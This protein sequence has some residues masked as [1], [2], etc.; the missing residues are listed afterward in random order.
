MTG[1]AIVVGAGIGGLAAAIGLRRIGWDVTVLE[2]SIEVGEIGAG[3]SQAPNALRALDAL[4]VG[5]QA[6]AAGTPFFATTNLRAPSGRYLM[7]APSGAPHSLLGFHRADLHGVLRDAVPTASIQTGAKVTGFDHTAEHARVHIGDETL[8]ADLVAAADGIHSTAR[9]LL[10]PGTPEPAF[11]NYTVWR[12][13]A[14]LDLAAHEGCMTMGTDRYFLTMPL[15]RG[16]VYWAL[17][18]RAEAPG[19]RYADERE[20]VRERVAGWHVLIQNL[21]DATAADRVLHHD[22]T[23]L[24]HAP[25]PSLVNGRIALLG[26]AAHPMSPDLGQGAGMAIEDAVVL[27]AALAEIGDPRAALARYDRERRSRTQ[28]VAKAAHKNGHDALMGS[29]LH[30][31]LLSLTLRLMTPTAFA[32]VSE[33]GLARLWGWQPPDLPRA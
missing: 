32:K 30:R 15:S 22:I 12:G 13:I 16:R 27:A 25:L 29:A 2:R 24:D 10:W 1:T 31:R 5:A 8:T 7:R 14:D 21:L 28:W 23:D 18:A 33:K 11:W 6:R 3:M 19:I 9:R 20:A 26:D 4:G 17:G